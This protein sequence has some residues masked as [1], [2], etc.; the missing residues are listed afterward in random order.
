MTSHYYDEY[1][2][3]LYSGATN[4]DY[5]YW[6]TAETLCNTAYEFDDVDWE[7]LADTVPTMPYLRQVMCL[8]TIGDE[9]SIWAFKIAIAL[10]NTPNEDV[11]GQAVCLINGCIDH[12]ESSNI[13]EE[14]RTILISIEPTGPILIGICNRLKDRLEKTTNNEK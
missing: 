6:F 5:W 4:N 13:D 10:L 14:L 12:I 11:F 3:T 7:A 9:H 1:I 8:Y 2:Q